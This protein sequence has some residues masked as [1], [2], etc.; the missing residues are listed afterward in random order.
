MEDKRVGILETEELI[1]G[2]KEELALLEDQM[3]EFPDEVS[4]LRFLFVS[5]LL[6]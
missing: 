6:D 4:V 3:R 5:F 2:F 1:S